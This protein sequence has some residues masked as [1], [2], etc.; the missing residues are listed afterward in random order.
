MTEP[1]ESREETEPESE[2]SAPIVTPPT[3]NPGRVRVPPEGVGPQHGGEP[4]RP[5]PP[6]GEEA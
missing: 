5:G 3:A 4:E 6:S 2:R 1:E